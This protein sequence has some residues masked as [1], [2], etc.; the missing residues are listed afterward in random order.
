MIHPPRHL[1]GRP[2]AAATTSRWRR[3]RGDR[4]SQT[5]ETVL[6]IAL[7]VALALAAY[8]ILQSK[9]LAK[10]TNLDLG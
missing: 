4:G 9:I 1:A 8:A 5:T 6:W 10:I 3:L 7:T 2:A